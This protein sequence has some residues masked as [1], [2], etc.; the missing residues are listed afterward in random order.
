MVY[1]VPIP[2]CDEKLTACLG[3]I[4]HEKTPHL[5]INRVELMFNHCILSDFYISWVNEQFETQNKYHL[6]KMFYSYN[7]YAKIVTL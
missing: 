7:K 6:Q 1:S 3:T 2:E 5:K 4:S